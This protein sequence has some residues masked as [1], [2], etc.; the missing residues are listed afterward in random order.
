[1][2]LYGDVSVRLDSLINRTPLKT[3]GL[4]LFWSGNSESRLY[5]SLGWC[6][7]TA[8]GQ[9]AGLRPGKCLEVGF[10]ARGQ[11]LKVPPAVSFLFLPLGSSL[12]PAWSRVR[13]ES[14]WD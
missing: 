1:M 10:Q 4:G 8:G 12:T 6:R 7:E 2:G 9:P 3:I 5:H 13:Q 14:H 11:V